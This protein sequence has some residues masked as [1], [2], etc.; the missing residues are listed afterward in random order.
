MGLI[1]V[2]II[3]DHQVMRETFQDLIEAEADMRVCGA[4]GSGHEALGAL[5]AL[6]PQ[7]VILDLSLPDMDGF[8]LMKELFELQP[9][10][11]ILIVSGHQ[12][13]HYRE[14]ALQAGALTYLDKIDSH[15]L[16]PTIRKVLGSHS[17]VE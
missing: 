3:E 11:N 9:E 15:L 12:A 5:S 7:V 6:L 13:S 8:V 4:A 10:I 2:F 16:M 1:D 17:N 14:M